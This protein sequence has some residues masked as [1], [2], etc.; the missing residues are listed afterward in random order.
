MAKIR[1]FIAVEATASIKTK[2]AMLVAHLAQTRVN[3]K[4]VTEEQ[5]HWTVKFLGEVES[6]EIPHI[7]ER[8]VSG[9]SCVGA[10]DILACGAGAF[11][12]ADRPRTLWLG[13]QQGEEAFVCLHRHIEESLAE[14]GFRRERRRFQPHLTIGRVRR[15][16]EGVAP[17]AEALAGQV[18]FLAGRMQVRELVVFAS[19]LRRP[20]PLY[21]QL[22][23]I[24]LRS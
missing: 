14:L 3:V 20:G 19:R 24:P 6:N 7:C 12:N 23:H 18:D 9:V 16:G 2:A 13:V 8:I 10:F 22:C 11:P 1:T 17:L 5:M 21:Q 15:S 4:W